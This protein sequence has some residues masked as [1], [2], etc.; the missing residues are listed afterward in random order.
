VIG[1]LND[2]LRVSQRNLQ[3][4]A[5]DSGGAAAINRNDYSGFFTRIVRDS[6]SYYLL[7]YDPRSK[8]QDSKLRRL[9]VKVSR[10]GLTVRARR[11]YVPRMASS[12]DPRDA[13]ERNAATSPGMP[14]DLR[15]ALASPLPVSGLSM[16]VAAAPFMG[17]ASSGSVLLIVEM[18]GRDLAL[19]FKNR[20]EVSFLA[21]DANG[22]VH[23]AR[24]QAIALDLTPE[25]RTRVEQTGIRLLNRLEL[26]PG[27]YQ[28][29]VAVRDPGKGNVG[30]VTYNL[31]VPDFSEQ[32]IGLSG[33]TL[34]LLAGDDMFTPRQDDQLKDVLPAAPVALRTFPQNDELALFA[35]VYDH[36]GS[37]ERQVTLGST[38]LAADGHVVH[39]TKE[40]IDASDLDA[41]KRSYRYS[42]RIP[43]GDFAPGRYVLK[44]EAQSSIGNRRA[45]IR[46]IAFTV[47]PDHGK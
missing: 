1:Q 20:V 37:A 12:T 44:V 14:A 19:G 27:R 46:Q 43:L 9:E 40:T 3:S 17:S 33:L 11:A 4:L 10:P 18:L 6:S 30:A 35:E 16:R 34:T 5:E 36:S 31:E 13:R 7:A 15:D 8:K 45:A 2:E 21:L 24:N 41:A 38:V 23:G 42:V 39:E 47:A 22:K 26:P 25:T 32:E 29:R 28:L